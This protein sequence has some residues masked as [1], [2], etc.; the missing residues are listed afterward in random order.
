MCHIP[1]LRSWLGIFYRLWFTTFNYLQLLDVLKEEIL[2]SIFGK[3]ISHGLVR[4]CIMY[5]FTSLTFL[6]ILSPQNWKVI[7]YGGKEQWMIHGEILLPGL[8]FLCYLMSFF[9]WSWLLFCRTSVL[10]EDARNF[11][12]NMDGAHEK[13]KLRENF[14]GPFWKYW[15]ICSQ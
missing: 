9:C 11:W 5:N 8:P 13:L 7:K 6:F 4:F 1:F 3:K 10:N 14:R 15:L 2:K 12:L